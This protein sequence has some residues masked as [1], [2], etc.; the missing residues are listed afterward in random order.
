MINNRIFGLDFYRAT[1]ILMVLLANT[2][3]F[4]QLQW[5]AVS[6][7]APIMGFLG[8]EIFLVLSG[9]LLATSFY[10]VF[11]AQGFGLAD[12]G[13]FLKSRLLRIVPLYF[14]IVVVNIAVAAVMGYPFDQSW[15]YFLFVQ[16]FA[17]SIPAFFPES[18]G[19]PVIVFAML[20]FTALLFGLSK[21]FIQKH[22]PMVFPIAALALL[23]VFLWTKWLYNS[24]LSQINMSEWEQTLRT[25]VLY[26]ID[27]VMVGV[28]L[29]WLFIHHKTFVHKIKG[30]L[31]IAGFFGIVFL[32]FGVGYLQLLIADYPMFW[33]VYYLPLASLILACFLPVL[34]NWKTA[35][36]PLAWMI[37]LSKATLGI[38]LTHFS[39]VL[40]LMEHFLLR[41]A[42]VDNSLG[43]LALGY[44]ML[45]VLIGI[46]VY[47]LVEKRLVKWFRR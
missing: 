2:I 3:F 41:D 6:D 13:T 25:V 39:I 9:F 34:A 17:T 22:K 1:A 32:T 46:L 45:S 37:F 36:K 20:M 28:L 44:F 21:I 33:N 10:P 40:L 38:Y 26:R 27:S 15:K 31:A 12:F 35:P 4:F 47:W 43:F 42:S 30:L 24:V 23:L 7:L 18:W 11:M 14:L 16:N 29:G 19:L 5:A 8:L